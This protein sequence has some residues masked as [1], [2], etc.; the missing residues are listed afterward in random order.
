MGPKKS[1]ESINRINNDGNYE[2]ENCEW[3]TYNPR[4]LKET[5]AELIKFD[6]EYLE[7]SAGLA[8]VFQLENL[9]KRINGISSTSHDEL[10]GV[11][12]KKIE[13]C[14]NAASPYETSINAMVQG[15]AAAFQFLGANPGLCLPN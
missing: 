1:G 4:G 7:L 5:K 8:K 12:K 14:E 15:R 9:Q 2:P 13:E 10:I 6:A 11:Y 3:T